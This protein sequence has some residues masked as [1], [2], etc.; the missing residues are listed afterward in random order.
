MSQYT[1]ACGF[2]VNYVGVPFLESRDQLCKGRR[3]KQ[4][5]QNIVGTRGARLLCFVTL[6]F[7]YVSNETTIIV[8]G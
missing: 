8:Y 1:G 7:M 3:L 4:V 5:C 2:V 6:W